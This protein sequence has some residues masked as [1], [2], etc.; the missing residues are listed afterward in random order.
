MSTLNRKH[1]LTLIAVFTVGMAVLGAPARAESVD[2]NIASM[3]VNYADLNLASEEGVDALY[4]RL[5]AAATE[6][7]RGLEGR[8]IA[9]LVKHRACYQQALSG[10]VA[11]LDL[12]PLT[13]LHLR[14]SERNELAS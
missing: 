14:R 4:R 9:K 5:R 11:K 6:V 3:A 10:A 1:L 8:E 12:A 2:R 13:A 7:C